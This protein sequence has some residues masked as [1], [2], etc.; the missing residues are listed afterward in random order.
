MIFSKIG[1]TPDGNIREASR[2]CKVYI[3]ERASP[4]A[5]GHPNV[6]GAEA[7]AKETPKQAVAIVS[8]VMRTSP[9]H[10]SSSYHPSLFPFSVETS[11]FF[12][13]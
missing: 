10:G 11:R 7:L 3:G 6:D 12:L 5:I 9:C 8:L 1:R 13:T 2:W 4:K